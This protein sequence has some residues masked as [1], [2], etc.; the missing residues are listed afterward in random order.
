VQKDKPAVDQDVVYYD[1]VAWYRQ[2]ARKL[3][4]REPGT[5]A[6]AIL[7]CEVM[8]QQT[9][10]ARVE[11]VWRFWMEQWP[12]PAALAASSPA[13]VLVAWGTLGYPRRALR[14]R[15]CAAVV[16]ERHHGVLPARREELL[17]LPGIGPYTADA[18][19]AFAYHRHSTV[20]DTNIRR[21]LA[22]WQTGTA[23]PPPT[24]RKEETLRAQQLVPLHDSAAWLWNA[25]LM[26]LGALICA[27]QTPRCQLCPLADSCRW[28]AVGKPQSTQPR[29]VQ[30]FAGTTREARGK[31][32][33]VLRASRAP[34]TIPQLLEQT[35]LVESRLRTALEGLVA[36]GL[37]CRSDGA[38]TLPGLTTADDSR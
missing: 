17:A 29:R 19:I 6:W 11:P 2:N 26:E 22:R 20:L 38:Y 1:V 3:P 28:L 24:L 25:A 23:L 8:S 35:S 31:V 12:T 9:P 16:V 5:D 21:V 14:L 15:E 27:A 7:V 18:I 36:D 34:V 32:M 30:A 37:A 13:E 10:V 33:A 4:W